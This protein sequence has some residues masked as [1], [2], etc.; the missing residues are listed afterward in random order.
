V[1]APSEEPTSPKTLSAA[2]KQVLIGGIGVLT[3]SLWLLLSWRHGKPASWLGELAYYSAL[4][5]ALIGAPTLSLLAGLDLIRGERTRITLAVFGCAVISVLL[6]GMF[7]WFRV[8][9]LPSE[10]Q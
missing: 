8:R 9:G 3:L 5:G 6:V 2:P 4:I 10:G 7:L 1:S